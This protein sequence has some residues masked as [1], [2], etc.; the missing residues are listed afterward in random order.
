MFSKFNSSVH[1]QKTLYCR[2]T[3]FENTKLL[4]IQFVGVDEFEVRLSELSLLQSKSEHLQTCHFVLQIT[5]ANWQPVAS[6]T[7]NVW[8]WSSNSQVDLQ[9]RCTVEQS[10]VEKCEFLIFGCV[11]EACISKI[12]GLLSRNDH[13]WKISATCSPL[14]FLYKDKSAYYYHNYHFYY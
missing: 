6:P 12:V 5:H 2:T 14:D 1:L 10:T 13:F 7:R 3:H 9:K 4:T 8:F 11:V